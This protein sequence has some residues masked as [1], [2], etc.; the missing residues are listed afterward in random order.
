M[1]KSLSI[2][3]YLLIDSIDLDFESGFSVITGETGAGKSIILGAVSLLLGKRADAEIIFDKSKKCVIEA[4]FINSSLNLREIFKEYDLDFETTVILRRE[5]MPE[6]KSRAFINDTPVNLNIL[7]NIGEKLIDLHSQHENLALGLM[8]YRTQI[9]DIDAHTT[10]IYKTYQSKYKDYL[11]LNSDL[12]ALKEKLSLLLKEAD[13]YKFQ[14]EQIENAQLGDDNE[15]EYLEAQSSLL[16][17][18]TEIKSGLTNVIQSLGAEQISAETLI[19]EAKSIVSKLSSKYKQGNAIS[20]RLDSI[21]IELR[22]IISQINDD[23]EKAEI[24]PEL[25]EKINSR[26]DLINKLLLKH[27]ASS[28]SELKIKCEE[29]QKYLNNTC[30]I[31]MQIEELTQKCNNI[32]SEIINLA[33]ELSRKRSNSFRTLETRITVLLKDLGINH[34]I[35]EI[36]NELSSE[37]DIQGFDN[38]SFL[39]SANKSV[40]PAPIEKIASGG[41]YSRL[42]L[43]LKSVVAEASS[44]PTIIFD[45]IDTGVSGEIASKMSKIMNNLAEGFQVISI[46]HLPQI[47]A[48]GS[49]HYK[50]YKHSDNKR[51]YTN[52]KLLSKD[53]RLTEIASMISGEILSIQ[54]IENAKILLKENI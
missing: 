37:I 11:N 27:Q 24:N 16:E 25:L 28:I 42:M 48:M 54:A 51:S 3:N 35:F 9:V 13:Y 45:E 30:E 23:S 1:L 12:K 44:I 29:F 4:K 19:I 43:A 5:I 53:E 34:A 2:N 31:E 6:G 39:F 47:A 36:H 21:I 38:L 8:S 52:I 50:V 7:K 20:N 10:D 15:L 32:Y 49:Y 46:T 18:A 26:I 40:S 33:K 17:N 22:D 14:A 41:E